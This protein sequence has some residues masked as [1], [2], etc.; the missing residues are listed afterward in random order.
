MQMA[1]DK[2]SNEQFKEILKRNLTPAEAI[3]NPQQLRG[4][5][6]KL[7]QIERAFNSTG[8]H[9]FIYGDRGVGKTSLAQSAAVLHQSADAHPIIVACDQEVSFFKLVQDIVAKCVPPIQIIENKKK[10]EGFSI[11]LP[12]I[13][14]DVGASI[15]NRAVPLPGSINEAVSFLEFVRQ[16]HSKE[17]VIIIDEFDQLKEDRDKKYFA[18]LVKQISDQHL[19][20]K[21]I[22]CGIGTSLE[23][24]IGLHLSTDRYITPIELERLTHDA[25][26]E[27]I[28]T[29]AKDLNLSVDRE[30]KIRIGQISDGF[31]YYI[32]LIA[33][34]MF[35]Q[36]FDDPHVVHECKS[37]HFHQGVGDAIS[38]AQTTLRLAYDKATQKYSDDYQEVLWAVADDVM[39]RRQVT[40]IYDGSYL[41]IMKERK[42]RKVLDK[43]QFYNRMHSLQSDRHG[44]ILVAKGAGWYE[45]RENVVRG[46][47]RMRAEQHGITVGR[48]HF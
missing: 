38:S 3:S 35:W 7:T 23:E 11:K 13:S 46:Y 43:S 31:P 41:R 15:E 34:K 36:A 25:R 4:R 45:F 26:W 12:G 28:D 22:F 44:Q 5:Q 9:A 30:L 39:L 29:A 42:G 6:T 33:E 20:I 40:G 37:P 2:L 17:P 21:L 32:H 14:Y 10:S 48:D 18:D 19:G 8:M 1:V 27:I 16:F 24:L 47:V